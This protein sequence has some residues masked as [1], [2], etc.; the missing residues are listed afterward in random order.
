MGR[1]DSTEPV[2]TSGATPSR[3]VGAL[4]SRAPRPRAPRRVRAASWAVFGVFVLNG[5]IFAS[6]VSRIPA[7]RDGLE[8]R[9]STIGLVLLV[10]SLGSVG[11]LPLAGPLAERIGTRRTAMLGACVACLGYL[12]VVGAYLIGSIPLMAVAMAFGSVGIAT[13]DVSMNL[14]GAMVEQGLGRSIMPVY[15]A[16]FS[17]GTVIGAGVGTLAARA[18]IPFE[19]HVPVACVVAVLA[20]VVAVRWFLPERTGVDGAVGSGAD[21]PAAT[22]APGATAATSPAVR[23][24]PFGAWLEPRTLLIGLLV[25]S[26]ALTEGSANDWLSLASIEAFDLTNSGGAAMLTVF[27]V[28]MTSMRFLGTPLLDRLGRVVVL[29]VCIVLALVGLALFGFAP[30]QWVAIVGV[31]LWGCGAALGFPVGMSAA[32]DEPERAAARVSVVATIGY[33]AFLA[34]PPILG[35]IADHV[36]YRGALL[37][38]LVPLGVSLFVTRSAAPPPGSVG[39]TEDPVDVPLVR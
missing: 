27:L 8:L 35:F 29:R 23:S 33:T 28:A 12:G 9:P 38:I 21:V 37:C 6:W 17:G 34:G 14:E 18:E 20:V 25:L 32:S 5:F 31:V 2:A 16:G 3:G 26:A 36:G 19:V 1:N 22:T 24:N 7:V 13:W 4:G 10:G 39:A 15:H 11:S 30:V